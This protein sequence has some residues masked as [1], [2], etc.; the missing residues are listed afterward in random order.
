MKKID[1]AWELYEHKNTTNYEEFK[2][3]VMQ[4]TCP[5]NWINGL[6]I[7]KLC[8]IKCEQCWNKEI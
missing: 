1:Y 6:Y 5:T 3:I 7:P 2:N 4:N 8:G